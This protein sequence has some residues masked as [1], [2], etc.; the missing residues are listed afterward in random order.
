MRETPIPTAHNAFIDPAELTMAGLIELV[1]RDSCLPAIR[2]SNVASSIRRFCKALGFAPDQVPATHWYFRERLKRFQPLAEGIQPKRWQT[3]KSDV[4][5]ALKHAGRG[6]GQARGYVAF[7]ATWEAL[8]KVTPAARLNWGLSRL[9]RFCSG[10]GIEPA[11]VNDRVMEG[12]LEAMRSET[13]KTSPERFHRD[14]CVSWNKVAVQCPKWVLGQVSVPCHQR[15]YTSK[16]EEL[17]RRI[18]EEADAWLL[19][20]SQEASLL[21]DD[22]PRKPLRPASIASYRSCI[23]QACAGLPANSGYLND[24]TPLIALA[25]PVNAKLILQ[26]YLDRNGGKPSSMLHSIAHVLVLIADKT[27]AENLNRLKR[28]RENMGRRPPGM[29]PRPKAGMAQF[30]DRQNI[31]NLLRLPLKIYK[32]IR[33]KNTFSKRDM[34]ELQAAVAIELLLMR[35]IRRKNL[36]ELRLTKT[37]VRS[38]GNIAIR[39][40]ADEVKNAVDIDYQ[41]PRESAELIVF[42]IDNVLPKLGSCSS[43]WLFPGEDPARHKTPEQLAR[44]F[45]KTVRDHSGLAVYPH[46]M[47]HIGAFLYL[48]EHPHAFE[49]VRRVLGHRSLETTTRSYAGFESEAAVKLYDKLIL[50]MR[51]SA[52]RKVSSDEA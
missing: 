13:F 25:Q 49:V 48:S 43:D 51:D 31:E 10:R 7:S 9:G 20:M 39:I 6:P 46:L 19:L 17:P 29:M 2:Q 47:R 28:Y 35:P 12:F 4:S 34:L 1:K 21:A 27:D 52:E 8:R 41:M 24:E 37:I 11:K 45:K 38:R 44:Q 42:Y 5:F 23:R 15:T 40:P 22:A 26:H 36:A 18:R 33:G 50:G 3:I 32:R 14:V 16:W 30:A